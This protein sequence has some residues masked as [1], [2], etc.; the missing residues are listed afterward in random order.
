MFAR[1][2]LPLLALVLLPVGGVADTLLI[3]AVREAASSVKM[4]AN[5]MTMKMV[6]K[7]F[8]KPTQ[9]YPPVGDPPITRWEYPEYTVYFE[10]DK[11]ITS[12]YKRK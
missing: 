5:G 8:G 11:V 4:P 10:Y 12:V 1:S 6:E 7:W 3:E 9:K 2:L